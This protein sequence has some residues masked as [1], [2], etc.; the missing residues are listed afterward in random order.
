MLRKLTGQEV[1][2]LMLA[3]IGL[4][5]VILFEW[6]PGTLVLLVGGLGL[7]ASDI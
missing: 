1:F 5:T 4:I 7:A 6:L 3:T 2:W